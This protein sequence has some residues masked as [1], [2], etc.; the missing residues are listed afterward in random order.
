MKEDV[1][2]EECGK[3]KV[4]NQESVSVC[5]HMHRHQGLAKYSRLF[6]SAQVC[7][8]TYVQGFM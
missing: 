6:S 7:I 8:H 5:A 4:W 1:S 3:I 2:S